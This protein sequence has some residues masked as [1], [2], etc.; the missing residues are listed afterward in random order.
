MVGL[1]FRGFF[2]T[3]LLPGG[4]LWKAGDLSSQKESVIDLKQTAAVVLMKYWF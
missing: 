1:G 3:L 2:L 4:R